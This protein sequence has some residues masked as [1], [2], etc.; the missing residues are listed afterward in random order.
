MTKFLSLL[1][2]LNHNTDVVNVLYRGANTLYYK[3]GAIVDKN[4]DGDY[5]NEE[6]EMMIQ[7]ALLRTQSSPE[8]RPVMSE[9]ARMLEGEGLAERWEEW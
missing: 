3:L 5:I 1:C 4:L 7:V 6:V 2:K 8:D 9:V